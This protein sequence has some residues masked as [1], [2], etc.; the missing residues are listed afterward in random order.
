MTTQSVKQRC[1]LCRKKLTSDEIVCFLN[2][3]ESERTN[4]YLVGYSGEDNFADH[5][6]CDRCF[7]NDLDDSDSVDDDDNEDGTS[8]TDSQNGD[9]N[10]TVDIH[11]IL[12]E[13]VNPQHI[14]Q[15]DLYLSADECICE[16]CLRG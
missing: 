11:C 6:I 16:N 5:P 13:K 14:Y 12:C 8:Y 9:K 1:F 2:Q 15:N 3:T 7:Y 10:E 4:Y